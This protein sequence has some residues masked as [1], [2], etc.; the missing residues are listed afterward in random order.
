[1][2]A[3]PILLLGDAALMMMSGGGGGGKKRHG[4]DAWINALAQKTGNPEF[5]LANRSH[6]DIIIELQIVLGIEP[7][8]GQWSPQLEMAVKQMYGE[9]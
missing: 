5:D 2:N 6:E 9:L 1:M 7:A 3:L 4:A 8:D